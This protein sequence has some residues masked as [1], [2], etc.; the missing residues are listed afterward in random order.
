METSN[1]ILQLFLICLTFWTL[2]CSCPECCQHASKWRVTEDFSQRSGQQGLHQVLCTTEAPESDGGKV[3]QHLQCI[4]RP[5]RQRHQGIEI[6]NQ[7]SQHTKTCTLASWFWW[8]NQTFITVTCSEIEIK[9]KF[10]CCALFRQIINTW[11]VLKP[12]GSLYRMKNVLTLFTSSLKCCLFFLI[13]MKACVSS[14]EFYG[15][16]HWFSGHQ[17]FDG[18]GTLGENAN[19]VNT[20]MRRSSLD[21]S[22]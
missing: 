2:S 7:P 8:R 13:E 16:Y 9:F 12:D 11:Q 1:T 14:V 6:F 21:S 5:A 3:G 18:S 15:Q 20:I 4:R 22:R 19:V 17:C 10:C